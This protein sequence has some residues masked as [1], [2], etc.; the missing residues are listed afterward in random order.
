MLHLLIDTSN[1]PS[2]GCSADD[3]KRHGQCE[4]QKR[5]PDG[6]VAGEK[7]HAVENW[8]EDDANKPHRRMS[9][10]AWSRL[11]AIDEVAAEIEEVLQAS[12]K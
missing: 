1:V 9:D 7:K 6:K 3:C 4:D 10:G 2:C 11:V 5:R 12:K 8:L